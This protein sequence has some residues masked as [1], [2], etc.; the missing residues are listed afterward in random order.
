MSRS[1]KTAIIE[2]IFNERYDSETGTLSQP[3]VTITDLQRYQQAGNLYAFFKDIV[4]NTASGNQIWPQSVLQRGYTGIQDVSKGSSFRFIP[5]PPG[6]GT[7][8][9]SANT[10]APT[11]QTPRYKIET[12]SL[13]LASRRLGRGDEPWLIQVAVR[14]RLVE[15][16]LALFSPR[17]IL[18]VDHLQM[19]VKLGKSEIDAIFLAVEQTVDQ[20]PREIIISCEAKSVRDDIVEEQV[21]RQVQALSRQPAVTQQYILPIAMKAVRKSEI[22]LVEFDI[23]ERTDA[24]TFESLIPISEAVYE[25]VPP[26][27]GI[28]E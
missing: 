14:L 19:N 28:G 3:V 23:V 21:V 12:A 6:Q 2:A 5:L 22:F 24:P 20:E 7:A 4:R 9:I 18:T 8:F 26:V 15:T 16:H 1:K 10:L 25:L 17:Q 13:P 11:P 27:S